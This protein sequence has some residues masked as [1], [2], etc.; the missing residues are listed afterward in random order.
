MKKMPRPKRE[1]PKIQEALA[2]NPAR[3]RFF[4]CK[5]EFVS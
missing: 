5:Y 3:R 1:K 2:A 4:H